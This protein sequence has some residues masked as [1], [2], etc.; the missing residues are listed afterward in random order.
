MDQEL[1]DYGPPPAEY[2][3]PTPE[4]TPTPVPALAP[5]RIVGTY[6]MSGQGVL[7]GD[8]RYVYTT[9]GTQTS[10]DYSATVTIS[11]GGENVLEMRVVIVGKKE[12]AGEG[13]YT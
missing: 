10:E 5:E 2:T 4:P 12:F 13:P 6:E 3:T 8:S 11:S 1:R 7:T 9:T